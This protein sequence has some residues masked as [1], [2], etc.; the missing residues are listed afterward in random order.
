MLNKAATGERSEPSKAVTVLHVI[1]S[2]A[3]C[4]GGPSKAVIEMVA[5][6][7]VNGVDAEIATTNDNGHGLLDVELNK[8]LDYKDVPVRFFKRYSPSVNAIREFAYSGDFKK[9]L[10]Q[11]IAN[12]D[13]VHVHAVFSFCCSFTMA[14][15]RKT[16][17]P[18]IVRP[19]GQLQRWS[20]NQAA[21]KKSIYL[22][23]I[24]RRNIEFASAIQFTA[25]SERLE[26]EELFTINSHVIPLGIKPPQLSTWSKQQLLERFESKDSK[27]NVL[28]LSRL[29]EKK[30]LEL[31]MLAIAEL[32]TDARLWIAGEGENKYRQH[33]ARYSAKLGI[34]DRCHFIGHVDGEYKNALLQHADMFALTSYSENFGIA[35]LEAMS[36]GLAPLITRGVA[37]SE[38]VEE[39]SLGLV[40]KPD[41]T[42]IR[43]QLLFALNNKET[44]EKIG[45][46]AADFT[47]ANYSWKE[48]ST[49]LKRLYES[50]IPD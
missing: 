15:A 37:L 33:L 47:Q 45:Q 1:P 25:N 44:L 34:S 16:N 17:T 46:L 2:I 29:H 13:L 8:K 22:K 3:P 36:A 21:V 48:I 19:I 27:L 39:N 26:A 42:E 43:D 23:L 20:L 24:E 49:R 12:Y 14:L 41:K 9:W 4:R 35:V 10:T 6:L 28:Y 11:N 38:V 31:L 32:G 7:R 30:G 5:A 40:C 50:I 18:Y